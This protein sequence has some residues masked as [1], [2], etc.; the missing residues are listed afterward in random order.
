MYKNLLNG[1]FECTAIDPNY[2]INSYESRIKSANAEKINRKGSIFSKKD[3][4]F[5]KRSTFLHKGI[6]KVWFV[7]QLHFAESFIRF[8]GNVIKEGNSEII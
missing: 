7:D 1:C 8:D 2:K 6:H 5:I 3:H 4:I